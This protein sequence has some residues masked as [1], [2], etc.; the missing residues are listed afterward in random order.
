MWVCVGEDRVRSTVAAAVSHNTG[1]SVGPTMWEP[2]HFLDSPKPTT[3]CGDGGLG[4]FRSVVEGNG[5]T[6]HC[7]GEEGGPRF[8]HGWGGDGGGN[9]TTTRHK[10]RSSSIHNHNHKNKDDWKED[11]PWSEWTTFFRMDKTCAGGMMM[12]KDCP[13]TVGP[14][15]APLSALCVCGCG[16]PTRCGVEERLLL[17]QMVCQLHPSFGAPGCPP[18]PAVY[19]SFPYQSHVLACV[20]VHGRLVCGWEPKDVQ[21]GSR[22]IVGIS[23]NDPR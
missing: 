12:M 8:H 22:W 18:Q 5:A 3:L 7:R 20:W 10:S 9:G 21:N 16:V 13:E 1:R 23:Q 19:L 17:Q 14:T 4:T 6:F 15:S 2:N 11:P